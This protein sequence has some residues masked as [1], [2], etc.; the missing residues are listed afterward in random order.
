MASGTI[1]TQSMSITGQL[2]ALGTSVYL[3]YPS[4]YTINNC[5]VVGLMVE[6]ATNVWIASN[7]DN[8]NQVDAVL[9]ETQIAV[10]AKNAQVANHN[11][12]LILAKI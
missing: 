7:Y 6:L 8:V 2:S 1:K 9:F 4:G 11:F 10:G 5:V 12:R 3:S